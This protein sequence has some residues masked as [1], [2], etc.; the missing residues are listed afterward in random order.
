[1]PIYLYHLHT[2]T[3]I[4]L[5]LSSVVN[6][7]MDLNHAVVIVGW[8]TENGI[9]YW[10]IRNS[11]GKFYGDNGYMKL[12][13]GTCGITMVVGTFSCTATGKADA[14]PKKSGKPEP[15]NMNYEFPNFTGKNYLVDFTNP[16]GMF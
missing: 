10:K 5:N 13:R 9:P 14:I 7:M 2:L 1:M 4:C 16:D 6:S 8:G 3:E 11:W 15:C 12:K